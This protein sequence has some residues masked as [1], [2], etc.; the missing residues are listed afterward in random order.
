MRF[1]RKR[2]D[3]VTL[4]RRRIIINSDEDIREAL[5]LLELKKSVVSNRNKRI[6]SSRVR[7]VYSSSFVDRYNR[8]NKVVAFV[9]NTEIEVTTTTGREKRIRKFNLDNE[10]CLADMICFTENFYNDHGRELTF[11][12]VLVNKDVITSAIKN[13]A[14]INEK[15][16]IQQLMT[17]CKSSNIWSYG[18]D[19]KDRKSGVGDMYVEFK[20]NYGGPGGGL[21]KYYDVPVRVYRQF[22]AS[23][24]KGHSFW[25]L[26]RNR[27]HYSKLTGDK[28][29]K[30]RNAIN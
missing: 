29:G 16:R 15:Q 6:N 25:I 9:G 18:I 7:G 10:R 14:R 20:N 2:G 12:Y 27:Y 19:I 8:I 5:N 21:Y 26:I 23:P 17:R 11:G 22:I 30:L 3:S 24:S 1:F 28:R 13:N 4:E